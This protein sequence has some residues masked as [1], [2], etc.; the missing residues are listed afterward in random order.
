MLGKLKYAAPIILVVSGCATQGVSSYSYTPSS[1][2]A[3]KNEAEVSAPY[4]Q[5]WDKLVRELSKS[6]YVINNIDKESRIINLSFSTPNASQYIDCGKTHRTYT[7]GETVEKYDYDV[8]ASS[9]FRVA[10]EKQ[11][12]P[13]FSNYIVVK[14]NTNL[15]GRVNVYLAPSDTNDKRT[16]VTVNTRYILNI[17]ARRQIVAEHL[18]GN[19]FDRGTTSESTSLSFNTNK[20]VSQ[21][22]GGGQMV[23]CYS[24]GKLEKEILD[25]IN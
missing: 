6:F 12:H 7:R 17:Q 19:V 1:V 25:F 3:V 21:D 5:V 16:M 8:A 4:S 11:E 14:R 22:I 15:E 20:S 9:Q 10:T 13:A 24:K 23:T 2:S 18:N